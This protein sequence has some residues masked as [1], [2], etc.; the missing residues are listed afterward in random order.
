MIIPE[1]IVY[2]L[3]FIGIFTVA[4]VLKT[5]FYYASHYLKFKKFPISELEQRLI[6]IQEDNNIKTNKIKSLENE[7]EKMTLSLLQHLQ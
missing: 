3:C 6:L 7:L 2:L 4:S 1:T 5:L